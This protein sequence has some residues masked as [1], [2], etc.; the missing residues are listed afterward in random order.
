MTG[1]N[2]CK[3]TAFI[4]QSNKHIGLSTTHACSTENSCFL[5]EMICCK[6]ILQPAGRAACRSDFLNKNSFRMCLKALQ[7]FLLSYYLSSY[8]EK[9]TRIM[10]TPSVLQEKG[11]IL[12]SVIFSVFNFITCSSQTTVIRGADETSHIG[13]AL[14]R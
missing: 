11:H 5:Q 10:F 7:V 9:Y 8:N 1:M 12:P 2:A 13:Y 6:L 4:T 14:C 3:E